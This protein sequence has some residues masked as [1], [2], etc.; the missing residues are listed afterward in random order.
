[1]TSE[2]R[3][4]LTGEDHN[5]MPCTWR[6]IDPS[7]LTPCRLNPEQIDEA[8]DL[9]DESAAWLSSRGIEGWPASFR[10]PAPTDVPKDRVEALRRYAEIG[11]LWVLRDEAAQRQAIA[12]AVISHWPDLD[13]AHGWYRDEDPIDP[14]YR[15]LFDARYC[16]RLAVAR[17][18]AGQ[19]VGRMMIDFAHWLARCAGVHWLRL[20]CS[21]NNDKLHAY[22]QSLGF[23]YVSTVDRPWRKSGALFQREV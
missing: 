2:P 13:F 20:D 3:Q 6:R 18:V 19:N 10:D 5:G 4:L 9:L 12:T 21:K 22:Y 11:E 1:M 7:R 14:H 8:L 15:H 17:T 16:Y 23:E